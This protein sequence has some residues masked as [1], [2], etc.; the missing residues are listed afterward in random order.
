MVLCKASH[1]T[2][3]EKQFL[4]ARNIQ[5][6]V[7]V[8][9]VLF[10]NVLLFPFALIVSL[11]DRMT[12]FVDFTMSCNIVFPLPFIVY[13]SFV[14]FDLEKNKSDME[15]VLPKGCTIHFSDSFR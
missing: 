12:H 9:L 7:F 11:I 2:I 14:R 10:V 6:V 3:Y 8:H 1:N 5:N 13:T 15:A 4:H